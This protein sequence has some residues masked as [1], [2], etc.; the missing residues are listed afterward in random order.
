MTDN[1]HAQA[2]GG[3][4]VERVSVAMRAVWFICGTDGVYRTNTVE[5]IAR[6]AIAAMKPAGE[7]ERERDYW[8]A[9]GEGHADSLKI[10]YPPKTN[11]HTEEEYARISARYQAAIGPGYGGNDAAYA[12]AFDETAILVNERNELRKRAERAEGERKEDHDT[13]RNFL[14]RKCG[15]EGEIKLPLGALMRACED[16]QEERDQA[17]A[18]LA[19]YRARVLAVFDAAATQ[20]SR[21]DPAPGVVAAIRRE[22]DAMQ[23]DGSTFA[24]PIADGA[25]TIAKNIAQ[26]AINAINWGAAR[27]DQGQPFVITLNYQPVSH[28]RIMGMSGLYLTIPMDWHHEI[29]LEAFNAYRAYFGKPKVE[30][31]SDRVGWQENA[32]LRDELETQSRLTSMHY[33]HYLQE[34][35][36]CQILRR[37]SVA[38]EKEGKELKALLGEA[39]QLCDQAAGEITTERERAAKLDAELAATKRECNAMMVRLAEAETRLLQQIGRPL[40]IGPI[41]HGVEVRT[42]AVEGPNTRRDR[43]IAAATKRLNERFMGEGYRDSVAAAIAD[44]IEAAEDE[45]KDSVHA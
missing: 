35:D 32:K 36:D 25:R 42:L 41:P 13:I 27:E 10:S 26:E 30:P 31:V 15:R 45:P 18:D 21:N 37:R 39:K 7:V 28:L 29:A 2:G 38:A 23:V 8:M 34:H 24:E 4:E 11:G 44:A 9:V 16:A 12:C 22:V 17:R 19:A 5:E 6:A 3:D 43:I 1:D 33:Q 20:Y 14:R 40:L